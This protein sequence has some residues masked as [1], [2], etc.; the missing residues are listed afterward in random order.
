MSIA[1][2][3]HETRSSLGRKLFGVWGVRDYYT[4]LDQ[5]AADGAKMTYGY[6]LMVLASAAMAT[7]GLLINS[8]AIVI[9]SMCVAPF[10]VPRGPC[11]LADF[12][13]IEKCF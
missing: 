2:R 11:V 13:V 12:F 3:F 9:G 5:I 1:K 4:R 10:L 8:S 7:G 6:V